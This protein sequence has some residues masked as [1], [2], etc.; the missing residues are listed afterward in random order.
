MTVSIVLDFILYKLIQRGPEKPFHIKY[1][2]KRLK[3]ISVGITAFLF[4]LLSLLVLFNGL[5]LLGFVLAIIALLYD[6]ILA[7]L[8]NKD[9]ENVLE[10]SGHLKT[11][12]KWK[13]LVMG[14]FAIF[15]HLSM[16][17]ALTSFGIIYGLGI[18]KISIL[19]DVILFMVVKEDN[20]IDKLQ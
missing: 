20:K 1:D 16:I 9:N 10:C 13:I 8:V 3:I 7:L 5:V 15:I 2:P 11:S 17:W 18:G 6:V 4:H 12:Q 19:W 14:A